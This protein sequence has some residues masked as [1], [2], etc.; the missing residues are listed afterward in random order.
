L[1]LSILVAYFAVSPKQK[2]LFFV[3]EDAAST[4]NATSYK[5]IIN[6]KNLHKMK[7]SLIAIIVLFTTIIFAQNSPKSSESLAKNN[8]RFVGTWVGSEKDKEVQGLEK[9]WEMKRFADGNF[10]IKFTSIRNGKTRVSSEKGKWW[11][12][13]NTFHEYHDNSELTD[14]YQFVILDKNRIR[15]IIKSSDV[16]QNPDYEFID[17]RVSK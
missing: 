6:N 2:K 10:E 3:L 9:K 15:F 7:K 12:E 11:I 14:V 1:F 8:I 4:A 17:T 16:V 5:I 13:N